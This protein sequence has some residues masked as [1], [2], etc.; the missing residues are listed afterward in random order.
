VRIRYRFHE[1][2]K[3]FDQPLDTVVIGRPHPDVMVH[4]DLTPD[5]RASRLHAR[6][7][8]ENGAYWIED[9]NSRN[10]TKI[11]G[12]EIKGR[13]KVPLT[14]G[15]A[16]NISETELTLEVEPDTQQVFD[17]PAEGDTAPAKGETVI[18][19]RLD[20]SD[21]AVGE[22]TETSSTPI[23]P[24]APLDAE[25]AQSMARLYQLPLLVD[26]QGSLNVLMQRIIEELVQMIPSA[27]RGALLLKNPAHH[28]T[29]LLKAYLSPGEPA[30]SRSLA[31]QAM[32]GREGF[33]W[34]RPSDPSLSQI[35]H[36]MQAGM[37]APLLWRDEALGVICIDNNVGGTG[38]NFTT[39]DLRLLVAATH[40]V[41]AATVQFRV[42]D[43]LRRQTTMLNNL[44]RHFSPKTREHL[45]RRA[46]HGRLQGSE[47]SEVAILESD[48]RGFT[49]LT[50]G[51]DADEVVELLNDYFTSLVDA[52]AKYDGTVDKFVGDA[53]LAIF[54]EE[55]VAEPKRHENALNAA[56]AMQEAMI[57]VS[58]RRK[59][60]GRVICNIGIGVH[61]GE[62]LHGFIGPQD[63]VEL[64]VIGEAVNMT[65][66][67]CADANPG[68]ILISPHIYE[69]AW[70]FIQDQG[71]QA[72]KKTIQTKHEGPIEAYH[73]HRSK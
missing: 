42:Q 46:R 9:L 12:Q 1:D 64:T 66:R 31:K 3:V 41:A 60:R 10:N 24:A 57:E 15:Q 2:E 7:T 32:T 13:G 30:V 39:D 4:V 70:G 58:A 63:R 69:Y 22:I 43:D 52:I 65:S 68:E 53:I 20:D 8:L 23:N 44:M 51:M 5:S 16:I 26:D 35:A 71:L 49:K 25:S 45:Q 61:C 73:L 54:F 48:I 59:T 27:R 19:L 29:L 28:D 50:A 11:D 62:V 36:R 40:H 17:P 33:I 37:Y 55:S 72:E 56:L 18:D 34:K 14:P 47:R 38:P 67:Y 21:L 6:I